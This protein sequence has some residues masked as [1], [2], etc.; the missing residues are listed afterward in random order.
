VNG[1]VHVTAKRGWS[2]KSNAERSIPIS[3]EFAAWLKRHKERL[4]HSGPTD[5]V[6][7]LTF[8]NDQRWD[9]RLL[10][11]RLTDLFRAAG[12]E[13]PGSRHRLHLIRGTFATLVLRNGGDLESLRDILGHS[14][15]KTTAGYLAATAQSKRRAVAGLGLP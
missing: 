2:P 7:P 5:P 15:L 6:V 4:A 13:V 9:R 10:T 8:Q 11:R 1:W 3:E 14:D 12:V